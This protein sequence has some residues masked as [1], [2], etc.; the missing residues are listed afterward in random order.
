[1]RVYACLGGRLNE[2]QRHGDTEKL[3]EKN[4]VFSVPLW[5]SKQ[6]V[7]RSA[8]R[9]ATRDL[10][11]SKL[12]AAVEEQRHRAVVDKRDVHV[13]LE[14][15]GLDGEPLTFDLSDEGFVELVGFLRPRRGEH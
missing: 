6:R 12:L 13:S 3:R 8:R 15:A 11:R 7:S 4:S 5:L 14:L 2:P 10:Q 9:A 1:M